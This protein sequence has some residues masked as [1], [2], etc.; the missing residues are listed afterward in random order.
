MHSNVDSKDGSGGEGEFEQETG[1]ETETEK[2][3]LD[4]DVID[5]NDDD[6]DDDDD[7]G[8]DDH[9]YRLKSYS[10]L[11]APANTQSVS[12]PSAAATTRELN[13]IPP[14]D[15][16]TSP[17]SSRS[18][19]L[20]SSPASSAASSPASV[21]VPIHTEL[22]SSTPICSVPNAVPAMPAVPAVAIAAAGLRLHCMH[23]CRPIC[24]ARRRNHLFATTITQSRHHGREP[25]HPHFKRVRG[26]RNV[27]RA[28]F[29]THTIAPNECQQCLKLARRRKRNC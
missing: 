11:Q 24:A 21:P 13:E 27:K 23:T 14:L 28:M 16:P 6:D 20:A 17:A 26:V 25:S 19:S 22:S 3:N 12:N 10:E 8:D 7:D 4:E 9:A 15:R 1:T 2:G 5:G 18:S 29:Q